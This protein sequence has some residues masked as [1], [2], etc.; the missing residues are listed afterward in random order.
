MPNSPETVLFDRLRDRLLAAGISPRHVGRYLSELRDHLDDLATASGDRYAGLMRLGTIDELTDA[1]LAR[2]ELQSWIARAPWAVFLVAPPVLLAVLFVLGTVLV[3]LMLMPYHGNSAGVPDWYR[4]VLS[5]LLQ[6]I[7]YVAPLVVGA[8]MAVGAIRQRSNPVWLLAGVA[9]IAIL[10]GATEFDLTYGSNPGDLGHLRI[11]FALLTSA[12]RAVPHLMQSAI[13]F[14]L[15]SAP[16]LLWR[17][18]ERP[19]A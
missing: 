9:L 1:A 7:A 3:S 19:A 6:K 4:T 17:R 2:P 8:V 11:T 10:A 12:A 5:I 15:I 13:I 14:V 18:R 16:Y